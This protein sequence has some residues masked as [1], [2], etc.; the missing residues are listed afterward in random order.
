MDSCWFLHRSSIGPIRSDSSSERGPS[1]RNSAS[2]S[3]LIPSPASGGVVSRGGFDTSSRT[4]PIQA[5][6]IRMAS[7]RWIIYAF[8]GVIAP[9]GMALGDDLVPGDPEASIHS[10]MGEGTRPILLAAINSE[11]VVSGSLVGVVSAT[12]RST[13]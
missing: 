11:E 2:A 8:V 1:A 5:R 6:K 13:P 12:P 9:L 10:A 4:W 7:M 3:P